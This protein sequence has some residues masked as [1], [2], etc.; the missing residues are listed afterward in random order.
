MAKKPPFHVR[1]R[2][3]RVVLETDS[4]CIELSADQVIKLIGDLVKGVELASMADG[5]L[6]GAMATRTQTQERKREPD[7]RLPVH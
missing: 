3:G 6:I 7:D 5:A 2:C 1:A 4:T